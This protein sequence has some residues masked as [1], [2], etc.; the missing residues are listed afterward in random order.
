[1]GTLVLVL[2]LVHIVGGVFWA[3]TSF[4]LAGFLG[5]SVAATAPDGGKVMGHLLAR[6]RFNTVIGLAATLTAVS[7]VI[8]FVIVSG[9]LQMAWISTPTGLALSIG[10]VAG[11]LGFF[12]GMTA[13]LP[14]SLRTASLVRE[15]AASGGPPSPEQGAELGAL[16]AKSGRNSRIVAYLLVIAVLGMAVTE[17]L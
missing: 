6:T 9:N 10:A 5:P 12:H 1:M 14:T 13:I 2:R 7:G 16:A 4:F 8:L 11:L 15:I 17:A 3:G